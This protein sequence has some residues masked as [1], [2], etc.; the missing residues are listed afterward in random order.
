MVEH[1][2]Q[3]IM[4][5]HKRIMNTTH[6]DMNPLYNKGG[7][8]S[9]V[10]T[11]VYKGVRYWITTAGY[12][13][14]AYVE[15][16]KDFLDKH[17]DEY[18][19]IDGID[20]HGGVTF[21]GKPLTLKAFTEDNK[22]YNGRYFRSGIMA[23]PINLEDTYVF[24]WDYAHCSDW[25]AYRSDEDNEMYDARKWTLGEVET[26]CHNAI[27]QYLKILEEDASKTDEKKL[28]IL[29]N[30]DLQGM[31]DDDKIDLSGYDEVTDYEIKNFISV[32]ER[33]GYI[34]AIIDFHHD[35][36]LLCGNDLKK[37]IY[38]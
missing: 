23:E 2:V 34:K 17:Q 27:D 13:P 35:V 3:Q 32:E 38:E 18:D 6:K 8:A 21:G 5:D 16:P 28:I 37:V 10:K 11:N 19:L 36:V 24:G 20:V 33:D 7:K 9:I 1:I 22:Y 4:R 26:E 14:C 15:C 25:E 29:K 30:R 31:A 12:H